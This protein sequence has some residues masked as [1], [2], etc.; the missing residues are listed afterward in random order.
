M[1]EVRV[2]NSLTKP[3]KLEKQNV[4]NNLKNPI[5]SEE[6]VKQI[7]QV[8]TGSALKQNSLKPQTVP[9]VELFKGI[10]LKMGLPNDKL[11]ILILTITRFF[12]ISPDKNLMANLRRETLNPLKAGLKTSEAAKSEMEAKILALVSAIDKGVILLPEAMER[13]SRFFMPPSPQN[14]ENET[15]SDK[16]KEKNREEVPPPEEIKA[17]T[18]AEAQ[19]DNLLDYMNQFPGKTGQYWTVFPLN[20]TIRGIGLKVILRILKGVPLTASKEFFEGQLIA[21]ISSP[22]RQ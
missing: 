22:R 11:S 17:I 6:P 9:A 10:A 18:E 2:S 8:L 20:L 3:V 15:P 16:G 13:Y 21:D 5:K 1:T 19:K 4:L 7:K 12:S 14:Q